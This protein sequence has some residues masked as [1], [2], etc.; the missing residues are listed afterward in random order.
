MVRVSFFSLL[1]GL[2]F[3]LM[4]RVAFFTVFSFMSKISYLVCGISFLGFVF[5]LL[6]N[7]IL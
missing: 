1:C 5:K 3:A 6:F 7:D 2:V 4:S